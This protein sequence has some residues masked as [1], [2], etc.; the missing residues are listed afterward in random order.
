MRDR[1]LAAPDLSGRR[2]ESLIHFQLPATSLVAP[3][4]HAFVRLLVEVRAPACIQI[5][6][7]STMASTTVSPRKAQ[8][9]TTTDSPGLPRNGASDESQKKYRLSFYYFMSTLVLALLFMLSIPLMV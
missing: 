3:A 2:F 5:N 6:S 4:I 7:L 1:V 9:P 8:T